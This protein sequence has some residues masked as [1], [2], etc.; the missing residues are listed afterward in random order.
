MKAVAICKS[1][2]ELIERD[3]RMSGKI[4]SVFANVCNVQ[5]KDNV[6]LSIIST[7]VWNVP[8]SICINL[9]DWDSMYSLGLKVGMD[10]I[11][12]PDVVRFASPL[13]IDLAGAKVW[14]P[15]PVLQFSPIDSA[16]LK[17]NVETV[18][19]ILGQQGNFAGIGNVGFL[20]FTQ[21]AASICYSN[22]L[23]QNATSRFL[24]PEIEK[25]L[26]FILA[27]D[28]AGI[29]QTV[30]GIVGC[31]PGLTP[32]AD[33]FL[34][35]LMV[36]LLYSA[37]NFGADLARAYQINRAIAAQVQNRT[38]RVSAEMLRLASE[39]QV[40]E[41]VRRLLLTVFSHKDR[42]TLENAVLL[43]LD[44]GDTSGSDL[45]AGLYAGCNLGILLQKLPSE[46]KTLPACTSIAG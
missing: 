19:M 14:D 41:S 9:Q 1:A 43:V 23:Q 20:L 35:G 8:R 46:P 34:C 45:V 13:R 44:H 37:A 30:Q 22:K 11:F 40:A 24:L 6:L 4:Q 5:T 10:V 33:D 36:S 15:L 25:L 16:V 28:L 17:R 31:G 27:D 38:T 42:K 12:Q 2:K 39:G 7:R 29:E 26:S 32:A 3:K 18:G 21:G